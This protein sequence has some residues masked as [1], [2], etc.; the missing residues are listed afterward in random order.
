[1][2]HGSQTPA[3]YLYSITRGVETV[4]TTVEMKI[5]SFEA[6]SVGCN[7]GE[8]ESLPARAFVV[9]SRNE[10]FRLVGER[11]RI[12]QVISPGHQH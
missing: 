1:M 9:K 2:E 10:E 12:N 7:S 6:G 5:V 3:C 8:P 4:G 11:Q